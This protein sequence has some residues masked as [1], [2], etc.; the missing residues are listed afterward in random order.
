M[1][2]ILADT[3]FVQGG[4]GG[5]FLVSVPSSYLSCVSSLNCLDTRSCRIRSQKLLSCPKA[6]EF[7]QGGLQEI[8]LAWHLLS[9]S[10]RWGKAGELLVILGIRGCRGGAEGLADF[11]RAWR[12]WRCGALPGQFLELRHR[13]SLSALE[14]GWILTLVSLGG[15]VPRAS[16]QLAIRCLKLFSVEEGGWETRWATAFGSDGANSVPPFIVLGREGETPL[17]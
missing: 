2:L 4:T 12:A 11:L 17:Y 14:W 13:W 3:S 8:R 7:P 10:G 1:F 6:V 16:A 9:G 15:G 5:L